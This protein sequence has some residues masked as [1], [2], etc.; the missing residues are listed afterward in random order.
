MIG[1]WAGE[2][3]ATDATGANPGSLVGGAAFGAGKVGQAFALD[4][5]DDYVDV[6]PLP[7]VA[8]ADG[9]TVMAWVRRSHG[10]FSVGGI[11][12]QWNTG[13]GGGN[14]FLLY[15][16]EGAE[17]GKGSFVVEFDGG[18]SAGV[19]GTT[20]LP[21]GDWIHVAAVW[22]SSDGFVGLYKNG[23]LEASAIGPVGKRLSTAGAG[24]AK[25][26]EWGTVRGP[27]YKWPGDLDEVAIFNRALSAAEIQRVVGAG[28]LSL[29]P[30]SENDVAAGTEL[31]IQGSNSKGHLNYE[32]D[33]FSNFGSVRLESINSG[34]TSGLTLWGGYLTNDLTGVV[35]INPGSG[36]ARFI[37]GGLL[38]YG[39]VN[40][41]HEAE[42]G[43]AASWFRNLGTWN[44]ET[45]DTATLAGA[46][47][48]FEQ[49]GGVL[50]QGGGFT[51]DGTKFVFS[52]GE[53]RGGYVYVDGGELALGN[54]VP[55]EG[56]FI[57]TRSS[58]RLTGEV[59]PQT[60]VWVRGDNRGNHTLARAEGGFAN[61]GT[62][63]LESANSGYSSSF[64]VDGVLTN[65]SSG[66]IVSNDGA[67]GGRQ[68]VAEL[69]NEGLLTLNYGLGLGRAEARHVNRGTMDITAGNS[70]VLD[71]GAQT[72]R[73]EAGVLNIAGGFDASNI[74]FE[75]AGGDLTGGAYLDNSRLV[76]E[77]GATGP[78]YFYL[79]RSGSR[80][81]G[82]LQTG[83]TVHVRGDNR[84]GHTQITVEPGFVNRGHVKLE[85][86]HAGYTSSLA[87]NEGSFRTRPGGQVSINPGAGGARN[88]TAEL[89]NEGDFTVNYGANLG[90]DHASHTN[91]GTFTVAEG[92]GLRL[93]RPGQTFRQ[94]AGLLNL[95]GGFDAVGL[96]FDF[97]GGEI[98][99]TPYLDTVRLNIVPGSSRPASFILTHS[100]S[101][102]EGA[103]HA[104]QTVWIRG[105]NR[106]GHTDLTLVPDF[107]NRGT[108][109]L[110]SAHAGYTT[111]FHQDS[112]AF[113]NLAGGRLLVEA[114]AGGARRLGTELQNDGEVLLTYPTTI[115]RQDAV[116]ANRGTFTVAS[117][118]GLTLGGLGQTFR[119]EAGRLD[120][121]GGGD[122]SDLRFEFL[123]GTLTGTPYLDRCTLLIPAANDSPGSF[124]MTHSGSRLLGELHPG[125]TV[126]VRGDNRGG[127]TEI[128]L[129]PEFTNRGLLRLESAH[130][131]YTSAIAKSEGSLVNQAGG[132][133]RVN[134][135]SGGPRV[136]RAQLV[137]EG[138][139]EGNH[140]LTLGRA[141]DVHVNR[142]QFLL[143]TGAALGFT[144][145]GQTLR[146][147]AGELTLGGGLS[148][149][150]QRLEY[151]GGLIEGGVYLVGS[152]LVFGPG[153]GPG[154]TFTVT[155]SDTRLFGSVPAGAR[156]TVRGDNQGGQ[157]AAVAPE[158][159][160]NAGYLQIASAH[161]GYTS[162]L[163]VIA[164][165]LVNE[166]GGILEVNPGSGGPRRLGTPLVNHGEFNVNYPV[167]LGRGGDAGESDGVIRVADGVTLTL[168][169][170]MQV[171]GGQLTGNG[172]FNGTMV[173]RGTVSP[174]SSIGALRFVGSF[175]QEARGAIDL[176]VEDAVA[177]SYDRVTFSGSTRLEGVIRVRLL[178]GYEPTA[179]ASFALIN[180]A[181]TG[182]PRL[183]LPPLTA[184]LKWQAKFD[185]GLVLTV[186]EAPATE[187]AIAGQVRGPGNQALPGL[188]VQAVQAD[189]RGLLA[190]F[191]SQQST[192]G[193]PVTRRLDAT[194][195][196]DWGGGS[197]AA[198]IG[199]DNFYVRWTGWLTP[200]FSEDYTLST[201]SDDGSWL[202]IDDQLVVD[203]GGLHGMSEQSGTVTLEAGRSYH[204]RVETHENS[205]GAGCRFYWSSASQARGP[206]PVTALRPPEDVGELAP[207]DY[208]TLSA[209]TDAAGRY[210]LPVSA[211]EWSVMVNGAEALGL[212]PPVAREVVVTDQDVTADFVLGPSTAPRFPDLVIGEV[213][214][215]ATAVGGQTVEITWRS[216]NQGE[217]AATAPWREMVL[218]GRQSGGFGAQPLGFLEVTNS[219]AAGEGVTRRLDV[220]LPANIVG[221]Y[222]LLVRT[223]STLQVDEGSREGNNL[224]ASAQP[225]DLLIGDLV[226]DSVTAPAEVK[227]GETA[228][229]TWVVRNAGGALVSLPW[230]DTVSLSTANNGGGT[231]LVQ[232]AAPAALAP[233]ETY[234]NTVVVTVP[235]SGQNTPGPRYFLVRTD[236]GGQQTEA[237]EG[238]N[239]GASAV[240]NVLA[241]PPPDLAVTEVLAPAVAPLGQPV[242]LV[243]T[244]KN[245]GLTRAVAPWAER[246]LLATD[247][248]GADPFDLLTLTVNDPLE[249]GAEVRRTNQVIFP[250][251]QVGERFLL[252]TTDVND[253]VA[254]TGPAENNTGATTNTFLIS[255]PNL[256]A[257]TL[258]VPSSGTLGSA[259]QIRWTVR[260]AGTAA[261][262]APWTDRVQLHLPGG[263]FTLLNLASDDLLPLAAGATY[264]RVTNVSLPLLPGVSA[265]VYQVSV[266][267]DAA[268]DLGESVETD[269][270]RDAGNLP[271]TIELP[272]LPDLTVTDVTFPA[273]AVAGTDVDVTW[274]VKNAG[275]APAAALW[276]ETFALSADEVPGGDIS[277]LTVSE[278]QP[279][280]PGSAVTRTNRVRIPA[281]LA[282][283]FSVFAAADAGGEVVEGNEANN[284]GAATNRINLPS[285]LTLELAV[286]AVTEGDVPP[287]VR[288]RLFRTGPVNLPLSVTLQSGDTNE[289]SA[290]ESVVI[291]AGAPVVDVNFGILADGIVDGTK[292][293]LLTA[294]ADGFF[295]GT[296]S[297]L[298]QDIDRPRLSLAFDSTNVLEG[299]TLAATV[300]RPQA[301]PLPLDVN[302][303]SSLGDVLVPTVVTI[304][305]GA[306]N[307]M[308][309]VIAVD[310]TALGLAREATVSVTASG[311]LP[312]AGTVRVEDNDNPGLAVVVEP[313]T[314]SESAGG[315]AARALV[316]RTNVTARPLL[317]QLRV[318]DDSEAVVQPSVVIRG[319]AAAAEVYVSAVNDTAADGPQTVS[320]RAFVADTVSGTVFAEAPP[321]NFSVTD[322]DGPTLRL[323]LGGTLA[324]EGRDP[325]LTGVVTRNT[326]TTAALT[327]QLTSADT[328]EATVPVT[329]E[330]PAGATS[331]TFPI[332][333]LNDGVVDGNQRVTLTAAAEGIAPGTA[334]LTVSDGDLPDLVVS[335]FTAPAS[336]V[337][338]G[339]FEVGYRITNQGFDRAV[340]T[341]VQKIVLSRDP[342]LDDQDAVLDE[343]P[344]NA[345]L[346]IGESFSRTLTLFLPGET[347]TFWIFVTADAGNAVRETL[348]DNNSARAS[349]PVKVEPAYTATVETD[350]TTAPAGTAIP[351]KGRAVRPNGAA[352]AGELVNVHV[353]LNGARR[354]LSAL[355]GLTGE[356]TATF[357]PLPN[358]AGS[359]TL[360]AAHPGVAEAPVQ[361]RFNL[362]GLKLTPNYAQQTVLPGSV[363]RSEFELLNLS[364][365]PLTGITA[366]SGAVDGL[367]VTV[368]APA[369]L[370][371]GAVGRVTVIS[372]VPEPRDAAGRFVV[373]LAS[374]EGAK[375]DLTIDYVVELP[376]PRLVATPRALE[377][378]MVRGRQTLV[379]FEVVNT[380]GAET[381]PLNLTFPEIPWLK[382]ANATPLAS[383]PPGGRVTIGLQLT[384]D[385]TVPLDIYEGRLA[386]HNSD[387][388][389]TVPFKF[390]HVSDAVGDVTVTVVDEL[391]YYGAGGPKVAGAQVVLRDPFTSE[392]RYTGL[393]DTNGLVRFAGVAEGS[394]NLDVTAPKH[395]N[396]LQTVAVAP[397]KTNEFTA[398]LRTQLVRYNWKVD[399]IDIEEKA[400]ITLETIFE[401]TVPVPVVTIEPNSIDLTGVETD[402]YQVELKFTNHGLIAAQDV[403]MKFAD[404]SKW[405]VHPVTEDIGVIP[406]KSSLTVPVIFRRISPDAEP[407]GGLARQ[408]L[409]RAASGSR[410]CDG[411]T[412]G[413]DWRLICGPFGVAYWA[414][415]P[416][417]DLGLCP[418]LPSGP[419]GGGGGLYIPVSIPSPPSG[420]PRGRGYAVDIGWGNRGFATYSATNDCSCLK[421]G[422]VEKCLAAEGGFKGELKGFAQKI[423]NS[424]LSGLAYTR[425]LGVEVKIS[426]S[427][428]LCTCC[429][430]VD[431]QGVVGLKAQGNLTAQIEA[432]VFFG[433]SVKWSQG[434]EVSGLSEAEG[435]F[436]AGGG[437]EVGATG[438][439]S[440]S[441]ATE[442]LFE[443]P[444]ICL[445]G[446]ISSKLF[447]GIKA[448][449]KVTGTTAG[450][451]KISAGVEGV[452]G[453]E[454]GFTA[455]SKTCT[456]NGVTTTSNNICRDAIVA[457]GSLQ[458]SYE[459][460][461]NES[462]VGDVNGF[463]G[464]GFS[465]ERELAAADC[466]GESSNVTPLLLAESDAAVVARWFGH[467]SPA[468]LA[469][470]VAPQ[471]AGVSALGAD[472]TGPQ[473][474][475]VLMAGMPA[476]SAAGATVK[477]FVFD[478]TSQP[479]N[480]ADWAKAASLAQKRAAR[481]A[482]PARAAD[483]ANGVCAQ[484]KLQIEQEAVVTRKAIGATLELINESEDTELQDVG[485]TINIYDAAGNLA[486]DR[487]IVLA[488]ELTRLTPMETSATD[489]FIFGGMALKL[490]PATT[491]SARWVILPRDEAAPEDVEYYYVGGVLAY[492]AGGVPGTAELTPGQVR[493]Y[494]NA[495]L[496]L[497][498]FHQRDVFSDDPFTDEVEPSLPFTLG[499][500]VHNKGRG[501]ARNMHITSAQPKIV[502][503]VKGLLIDFSIIATEVA[504]KSLTPSLRA[505]FGDIQPGDTAIGRWLLKSSLQGLFIDYKATLE[506]EDRFGQAG[507][508]VFD[509]IEIHELIH[510]VEAQGGFADG[511]PDFL[512]ND[513]KDDEDLPDTVHLSDAT[514]APVAVVRAASPDGEPNAN[515]LEI[516]LTTP[517]PAGFAY[518]RV[519]DPANG[520]FRLAG[521]KRSDGRVLPVDVNAWVTDRTFLGMGKR[522]RYENVLHLFD[523]DSIGSY[524]LTYA[525]DERAPDLTAP[526]SRVAS[527]PANSPAQ[528]PVSWS[529]QDDAFGTG[530]GGYDLFVSVN[531][532][533]FQRWLTNTRATSALYPG[534]AG[535]SYAFYSRARDTAGNVEEAPLAPQA[536]TF[537]TG[538]SAPTVDPLVPVTVD[539]GGTVNFTVSATDADIPAD[540][541]AYSLAN[542]PAGMTVDATTGVVSWVTGEADGPRTY[543]VTVQATDNG[544]PSLTGEAV[545]TVTVRELNAAPTLEPV[546]GI[547]AA[548]EGELLTVNLVAADADLPA[549]PLRFRLAEGAPAGAA[550]NSSGVL[551]WVPGETDGG[552]TVTLGVI[553]SDGQAPELTATTTVTAHVIEANSAPLLAPISDQ[554]IWEGDL[555]SLQFLAS[556]TDLPAQTLRFSQSGHDG[557]NTVLDAASGAF[558]WLPV[559]SEVPGTNHI[560]ITVTDEATPA[561]SASQSF[562]L[563]GRAL[564]AGL[565][566]PQRFANG[567][568]SFRFKGT[569]G[570]RYVLEGSTDFEVWTP[571]QEFVADPAILTLTD[572][573]SSAF[574]W[575]YF[576]A[577]ELP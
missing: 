453:V 169:G 188:A 210:R 118:V 548:K 326:D 471:S 323:T 486:N 521:V 85:S 523:H 127:Q 276:Q 284:T 122:F 313:G 155:R 497:K 221:R 524:T 262:T 91:R 359:Y 533:P 568:L 56:R 388:G 557:L 472:A 157:T 544:V 561:A 322:D 5:A 136:I 13:G 87:L 389:V 492:T 57:L 168:D 541:I 461:A 218:F 89:F 549:Q 200:E 387:V 451:Q 374:A 431:G 165:A 1:W 375:A 514:T 420:G 360:G 518:L 117:G 401:T 400:K 88:F 3:D 149:T 510:Q 571:L 144:S 507:A 285:K 320:L 484:V 193:T 340:G 153:A 255:A 314:F 270:E 305:A 29:P 252:V 346:P 512:V 50:Q 376:Q 97:A 102:L 554:V 330:I 363:A 329:V 574:P 526:S 194:V 7:A 238:N 279:L 177:A 170:P 90:R 465:V 311:H 54:G 42:F 64:Q 115:A 244:V 350:V 159:L 480:A 225:T 485:V 464:L 540:A 52:G 312:G 288:G 251:S 112:G 217:G 43:G 44:V 546:A 185:G 96:R 239:L 543:N 367:S 408:S 197:P 436:F 498:Y 27:A 101:R 316:S 198:N 463:A 503:N 176:E 511:K 48:R 22:R 417:I 106:G 180:G 402:E 482:K 562:R 466:P 61:R 300:S 181:F 215:P 517:M 37:R 415:V 495:K 341:I 412:I 105:D 539:E 92:V 162:A 203:N 125:Q 355:T 47:T 333:T 147:E 577:R 547:L 298:V 293:V 269:N 413:V 383:L 99:G 419:G 245:L 179:G 120:I 509:G 82:S 558:S 161:A 95:P 124:I 154:G 343:T 25:L 271:L 429:A 229:V 231:M 545:V 455:R 551:Q 104:G 223:D 430:E 457:K 538:N 418:P 111:S 534:A 535:R 119:Q 564:K 230:R 390:R 290:P 254:E 481:A 167:T 133:I 68:L 368:D 73:Q 23:A 183:E 275:T 243:W 382:A 224:T 261:I 26:G 347:G 527:L 447:A 81:A 411:P 260:N 567:D 268:G 433:P 444:E 566:R 143:A 10:D 18:G 130:A 365:L 128:P 98:V 258:L 204:V 437:V 292:N 370:A 373:Q 403:M 148:G 16:S 150:R 174:G 369:Q 378:G 31:L 21:V 69:R 71:A 442:C 304:P 291:P 443:N 137:N 187:L 338:R 236:A 36:G 528:I 38:N 70:L 504:G 456:K 265:G 134:P 345:A 394:Y 45:G 273:N 423:A 476:Q 404:G 184:G 308:F 349:S 282:G 459:Q 121:A 227:F 190:E 63:R 488:P 409:G 432:K 474:S 364:A 479:A 219:L 532:G 414:P 209:L 14:R 306:S 19:G 132:V 11:V 35:T 135:G 421:G 563:I 241:P 569:A 339:L 297:V 53:V 28:L 195:D 235:L 477:E 294:D 377:S 142:G 519:P 214:A 440:L 250:V 246:L 530:V 301:E 575:R 362:L 397:G 384:P 450:G 72:F 171:T 427:G 506:H 39:T 189:Y 385:E 66:K 287:V 67:G 234:T 76:V 502:E 33:G 324:R 434:V 406:A 94:E 499:V 344:F 452:I 565:N 500:M 424:A 113:R 277:L 522:P 40:V 166:A 469:A 191:W 552:R 303:L 49:A 259:V 446:G 280:A 319:G 139:I 310:D 77:P 163:D 396:F 399:E 211:G 100:A 478:R 59:G 140:D 201:I 32:T 206:V 24:T 309:T 281:S 30:E 212:E 216:Q 205:G 473:L 109:R 222:W 228:E 158:G 493:V 542:A 60:E 513:L 556:D 572:Q 428:K 84:G 332:T 425:L 448:S 410:G 55:G 196:F 79:T 386:V 296:A 516:V 267:A 20:L 237:D 475:S 454:G 380:G 182:T 78:G 103:L 449:G 441:A 160:A 126:W 75:F 242:A 395:D 138:T 348:E 8:G 295:A 460:P 405:S 537:T 462:E 263:R 508:S 391:T 354:R 435:E 392:A 536:T 371:P 468:A 83:Q 356:F 505:E 416:I 110:A 422:F 331:V 173:S 351:L 494:P 335:E 553:V 487:F 208:V 573:T 232:P 51:V 62:L 496:D 283:V 357:Q 93:D 15:N 226:V 325:A 525:R 407:N 74:Q 490:A 274:T 192:N 334:Q 445:E 470:V 249:P 576:R 86:A 366:K 559:E 317:V 141:G 361:D 80:L 381:G 2:N 352:A 286:A 58:A 299:L 501:L 438:Y 278:N 207:T 145:E 342:V 247:A 302:V 353:V 202:W 264:E 328:T 46:G 439:A 550:V 178:G 393:S 107:P 520:K 256:V 257:E 491:G 233:G 336:G 483:A 398:F 372:S 199:G 151:L 266:M 17:V 318:G 467:G 146:Q 129:A 213:A 289:I 123:G 172:T 152:E 307:V 327:V 515:D 186:E 458:A 9:L 337:T 240:I 315:L 379:E 248:A 220:T 116:H 164:G 529:G 131:G 253:D 272:P 489:S 531:G 114:G 570:R 108:L 555:L 34:Y 4:G 560:T 175:T 41:N 6:G 426:G 358:E 12:G 321:A 156:L 65:A